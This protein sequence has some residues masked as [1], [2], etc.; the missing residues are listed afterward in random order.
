M[1]LVETN[2]IT[3]KTIQFWACILNIATQRQLNWIGKVARMPEEKIQR[4]L[5]MSWTSNPRKPGRLQ[6]S[7]RTTD[8][9]AINKIIPPAAPSKAPLINGQ[10]RQKTKLHVAI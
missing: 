6:I 1:L 8:A 4:Q 7:P 3:N 10:Q 5:L 2:H 9:Q